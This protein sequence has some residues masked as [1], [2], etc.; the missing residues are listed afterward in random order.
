M[1]LLFSRQAAAKKA[2]PSN[3]RDG[4]KAA[5][6]LVVEEG[7]ALQLRKD[8]QEQ[9]QQQQGVEQQ[10]QQQGVEQL[11]KAQQGGGSSSS[12]SHS[13]ARSH[14]FTA[15][16]SIGVAVLLSP[17]YALTAYHVVQHLGRDSTVHLVRPASGSDDG[18]TQVLDYVLQGW[19]KSRDLAILRLQEGQ[20]LQSN[21]YLQLYDGD[22]GVLDQD[23]FL[24]TYSIALQKDLPSFDTSV[25][26]M[27]A[28]QV[29]ASDDG[30]LLY[31]A[32]T[33]LGCSGSPLVN[34]NGAVVAIHI[35]MVDGV[36]AGSKKAKRAAKQAEK[37]KLCVA[38]G[39]HV[40]KV[41]EW[42]E[43][44]QQQQVEQRQQ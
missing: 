2:K 33:F 9:E 39:L 29:K 35:E 30:M 34:T 5:V 10:E 31:G 42:L 41:K 13:R 4:I 40:K 44:Q 11:A 38:S 18:R 24:A 25:G 7:A 43:Q 36:P 27:L 14:G 19:K 22:E 6:L 32:D 15:K 3:I 28:K 16:N 21:K 37:S 1:L 23:L 26:A 12:S 8:L 17:R 20:P